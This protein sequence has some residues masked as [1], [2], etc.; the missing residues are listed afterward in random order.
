M[1]APAMPDFTPL[2][3]PQDDFPVF[4][5][6]AVASENTHAPRVDLLFVR[7]R[8]ATPDDKG[9]AEV[10]YHQVV[11][12]ALPKR[13]MKEL[14][15]N[16]KPGVLDFSTHSK[17]LT[18]ARRAFIAYNSQNPDPRANTRYAE[19][20]EVI[21]FCVASH[22]LNAGQVAAKMALKTNSEMP[23]FGLDGIHV[24]AESDATITVYFLEAKMV[25]DAESGASQYAKSAAGF[26]KDRA[27]ELN[28]KRI[29]RDLS[30]LDLLEAA[31]RT[32]AIEYF[33]PYGEKQTKVR[34]RFVGIII[35]SESAYA[36]KLPVND[37]TPLEAHQSN[38]S[39]KYSDSHPQLSE[40]LKKSLKSA[41]AEPGQ[42]RAFFLA[43]PDTDTLKQLF[44]KEMTGEHIR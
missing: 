43:V 20:G 4:V 42:C 35:H 11:N 32:S 13:K 18:E 14:L 19:I 6:C 44:A 5:K 12:Y 8:E 9:L 16:A 1:T 30:N 26:A 31:A 24:K 17:L 33:D 40:S 25:G 34:E 29:A 7:F 2:H 3:T 23:V 10:V 15:A 21:A 39:K 36:D 41:G 27:H 37:A 28:E 22:F 38:F